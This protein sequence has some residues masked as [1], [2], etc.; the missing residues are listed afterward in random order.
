MTYKSNVIAQR[1]FVQATQP[2][3]LPCFTMNR[4]SPLHPLAPHVEQ[5][6]FRSEMSKKLFG[7]GRPSKT[8]PHRVGPVQAEILRV[9]RDKPDL[10][11]GVGIAGYLRRQGNEDVSDAQTYI[12][13]RRLD[14]RGLIAERQSEPD[15]RNTPSDSRRGRPHKLY[16]LTAS[17]KRALEEGGGATNS[18]AGTDAQREGNFQNGA[19]T[20]GL[21]PVVG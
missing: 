19:Q 3:S 13:L 8:S 17:G 11:H 14:A 18:K 2:R 7:L 6:R 5:G 20:K 21:T 16:S 9:I 1:P 12:A 4:F 10:A 15:P